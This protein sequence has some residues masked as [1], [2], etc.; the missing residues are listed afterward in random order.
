MLNYK[1]T[2]K[3]N[4]FYALG[5][6]NKTAKMHKSWERGV[7]TYCVYL[8]PAN[9][10]GRSAKGTRINVC[11]KSEHC[12]E[13][14]LNAS[15]HNKADILNKGVKDSVINRSRINKTR[16]FYN[17]RN[18]Y[19][20]ILIHEIERDKKYA[21]A[22]DMDFSIRLNG[23]SDLSPEIMA[24]DGKNILEMY[25]DV[26]FY[27]YTKVFT[28][29]R[30]MNVYKNYDLTFSFDGYNWDECEKFLQMNGKVAVVFD[31]EDLPKT[32]KGYKVV[33]ANE[34][35]MRYIDPKG[36][37]MGLSFHPVALNGKIVHGQDVDNPFVV[38]VNGN[39]DCK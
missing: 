34:Y 20:D 32:Y 2:C 11:P 9:M 29:V 27:D 6:L 14:C 3:E 19:M 31:T 17:D 7:A 4:G 26:Q 23:T 12:K 5:G 15:G 22:H 8:A 33:N 13:L 30:L 36:C 38:H 16:L 25:P 35:D 21:K 37:I 24:K 28:R 10:A 1:K 18:T 39:S